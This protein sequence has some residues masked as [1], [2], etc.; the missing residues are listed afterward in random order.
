MIRSDKGRNDEKTVLTFTGDIGSPVA[1]TRSSI[2]M[3]C[4][5]SRFF[6]TFVDII[7]LRE[8]PAVSRGLCLQLPH[9]SP[10]MKVRY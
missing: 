3:N 5:C 2:K 7:F 4:T 1:G 10:I 9:I 6:S 8:K